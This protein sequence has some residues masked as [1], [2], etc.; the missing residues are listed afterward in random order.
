[1][2]KRLYQC[3]AV[4]GTFDRLHK[5]HIALLL[6]AFET[7]DA[8]LIG[9]TANEMVKEKKLGEIVLPYAKRVR[10]IEDFLSERHLSNRAKIFTL[11]DI[12]GPAATD[13]TLR[14]LVVS[15]KTVA[16]G[17]L[18][19]KKRQQNGL[20]PL[21]LVVCDYITSEDNSYLSSTRL[22]FGEIDRVGRV[23]EKFLKTMV[24]FV[25]PDVVKQTLKK[26]LGELIEGTEV[27]L[28]KAVR[29]AKLLLVHA[30]FFYTVGDVV[31]RAFINE[32]LRPTIA[33]FDGKTKRQRLLPANA[34]KASETTQN[35][36]GTISKSAIDVLSKYFKEL[37]HKSQNFTLLVNGEEDLLVLPII[38]LAPLESI[39]FYGQPNEG[40]VAITVTEEAKKRVYNLLVS[41]L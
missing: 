38:L 13:P 15:T 28:S 4:A 14:A 39:V 21:K 29:V 33:I 9:V 22:R 31:S 37:K 19:N 10:D 1:M 12:Y 27:D 40:I 8:V 18:V 34:V 35:D 6:K 20:L 7:S 32:H 16:G 17:K 3:A 30:P 2:T 5:G 11:H 24:P 26:P 25:I 41:C 23:Y 36:P